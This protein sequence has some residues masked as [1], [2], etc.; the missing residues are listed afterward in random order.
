MESGCAGA[1]HE[2]ETDGLSAKTERPE[3]NVSGRS[4]F[5]PLAFFQDVAKM[6][7]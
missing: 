7:R 3:I 2:S 4:P 5:Y 6:R 1:K